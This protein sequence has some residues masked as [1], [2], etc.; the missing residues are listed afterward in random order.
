MFYHVNEIQSLHSYVW[1]MYFNYNVMTTI[2]GRKKVRLRYCLLVH[3]N[4]QNYMSLIPYIR[5]RWH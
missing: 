1:L 2:R 5:K 3:T 4:L